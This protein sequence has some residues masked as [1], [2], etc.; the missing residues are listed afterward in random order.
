MT[1]PFT[2]AQLPWSPDA[3]R[4]II[5]AA[6]VDPRILDEIAEVLSPDDWYHT[7]HRRFYEALLTVWRRGDMSTDGGAALNPIRLWDELER[8]HGLDRGEAQKWFDGLSGLAGISAHALGHAQEV[9]KLALLRRLAET[10]QD[11]ATEACELPDDVEVF[12]GQAEQRIREIAAGSRT[13]ELRTIDQG[14]LAAMDWIQ[15]ANEG[16]ERARGL[17]T[18][19]R[20]LDHIIGGIPRGP[21]WLAGRSKHGKS[22]LALQLATRVA[23]RGHGVFIWSG[24]MRE[25][26][27]AGRMIGRLARVD[28]KKM[29][30]CSWQLTDD[31]RFR[32]QE[33]AHRLSELPII[34][35][36]Q[37]GL[38]AA[39]VCLRAQ[40]AARELER[41]GFPL[42]LAVLDHFHRLNHEDADPRRRADQY[43]RRSSNYVTDWSKDRDQSTL[44]LAQL[45]RGGRGGAPKASDIRECGAAEEDAETIL[46]VY[47]PVKDNPQTDP[48]LAEVHVLEQRQ[49]DTGVARLAFDGPQMRFVDK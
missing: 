15:A 32:V 28:V 18:G 23:A 4:E 46:G 2:P 8:N 16:D 24:E 21:T 17:A 3:E 33:A 45:N 9:R 10:C 38:T 41:R 36:Y 11:I 22:A 13:G 44:I 6:F 49:G 29:L 47:R 20:D 25:I 5:A 12:A 14:A 43:M 39:Q 30:E 42:R 40:R 19:F 31:E 26:Q 35:D 48:G 7:I 34:C 37:T 1:D 27:T